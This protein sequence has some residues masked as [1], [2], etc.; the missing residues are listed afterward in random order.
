MGKEW[1][2]VPPEAMAYMLANVLKT[3]PQLK[4]LLLFSVAYFTEPFEKTILE[5]RISL[6]NVKTLGT[7]P[8]CEFMVTMC[9]NVTTIFTNIPL[10]EPR[11]SQGNGVPYSKLVRALRFSPQL[12]R[13]EIT[14]YL[15]E[16][17]GPGFVTPH[18]SKIWVC[19]DYFRHFGFCF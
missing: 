9:P 11:S 10:F 14:A 18:Q 3:M 12:Q 5:A 8:D 4:E 13:L 1:G 7:G 19:T 6:L 15:G 16:K 17:I 2:E